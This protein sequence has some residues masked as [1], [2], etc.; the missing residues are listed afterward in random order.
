MF[1]DEYVECSRIISHKELQKTKIFD[2]V[3]FR[4]NMRTCADST[5]C[6]CKNLYRYTHE[7]GTNNHEN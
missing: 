1:V 7:E 5:V 3:P 4:I 6:S 2:K